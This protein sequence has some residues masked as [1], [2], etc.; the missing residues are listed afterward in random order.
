[1]IIMNISDRKLITLLGSVLVLVHPDMLFERDVS[2]TCDVLETEVHMV[3]ISHIVN[4]KKQIIE[5]ISVKICSLKLDISN[6][7]VYSSLS[8]AF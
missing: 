8:K 3:S 2:D 4:L 5:N 7:A 6:T 1:M